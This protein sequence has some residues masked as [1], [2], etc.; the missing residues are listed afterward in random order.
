M[1]DLAGESF[2][3]EQGAGAVVGSEK[4][5]SDE[6]GIGSRRSCGNHDPDIPGRFACSER[7]RIRGRIISR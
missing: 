1:N 7:G 6:A 4:E 2:R 5:I 3:Q